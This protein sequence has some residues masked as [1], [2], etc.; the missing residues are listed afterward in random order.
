MFTLG[1]FALIFDEGGRILLNQ[2]RDNQRWNLPGGRVELGEL[3]TETV[4]RETYEETDLYVEV[5]RL[6]GFYAKEGENDFVPT[7]LCRIT[8]GDL[9]VNTCETIDCRYFPVQDI[10]SN[11]HPYHHWRILDAMH[12]NSQPVFIRQN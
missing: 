12:G 8:G 2:R 5:E 1:A 10:P 9:L 7:F 6:V 11:I 4:V 3:P